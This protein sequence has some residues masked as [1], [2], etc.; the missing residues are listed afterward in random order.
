M[1]NWVE[2]IFRARG[3]R[4]RIAKFITEGLGPCSGNGEE[5]F[6]IEEVGNYEDELLYRVKGQDIAWIRGT[7][8]HFLIFEQWDYISVHKREDGDWCFALPFK[9]AWTIKTDE[10]S[11]LAKKYEIRIKANGYEMGGCFEQLVEVKES[12]G[13]MSESFIEYEDY[14]WQCP[15]PLLGG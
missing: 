8:R 13:V 10:I 7:K 11:A 4:D 2:G 12:G 6:A 3:K 9:A 15:M 1:P 5:D 14:E